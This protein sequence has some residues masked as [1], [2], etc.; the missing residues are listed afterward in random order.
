MSKNRS[1]HKC[2][3]CMLV[4]HVLCTDAVKCITSSHC[5]RVH[6]SIGF[7]F[8]TFGTVL[9]LLVSQLTIAACFLNHINICYFLFSF[10]FFHICLDLHWYGTCNREQI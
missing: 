5:V 2:K 4:S 1:S 8:E 9:F 3:I 6:C 7:Y 10:V